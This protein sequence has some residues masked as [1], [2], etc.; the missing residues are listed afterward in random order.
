LHQ[1]RS[2]HDDISRQVTEE[3]QW[4]RVNASHQLLHCLKIS[5][6]FNIGAWLESLQ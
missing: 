3:K 6:K 1:V 5:I 4:A 2:F